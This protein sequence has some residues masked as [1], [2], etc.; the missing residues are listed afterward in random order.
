MKRL[1]RGSY[2][3]LSA[4][5]TKSDR[6]GNQIIADIIRIVRKEMKE[7]SSES[8]SSILRDT[9]E[10]VKRFSWETVWMEL[11]NKVPTLM[12][13]LSGLVPQ[14]SEDKPLLCLLVS[15]LVKRRS[16]KLS[17]VQRAVSLMLY[18]NGTSKQ[19]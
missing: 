19:V 5:L 15:M 1:A 3:A 11:V 9:F 16:P 7:L 10:A 17:L 12:K 6:M 18:G 14:P 4:S 8:H 2:T 13:I